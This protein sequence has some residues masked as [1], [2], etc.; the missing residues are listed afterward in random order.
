MYN[1]GNMNRDQHQ[2]RDDEDYPEQPG[3]SGSGAFGWV[4]ILI[5]VLVIGGYLYFRNRPETA[6]SSSVNNSAPAR[7]RNSTAR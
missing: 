6:P 3:P 1:F 5:I 7:N 2:G 4:L